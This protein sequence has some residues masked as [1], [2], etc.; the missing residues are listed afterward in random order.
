MWTAQNTVG[1][2][3]QVFDAFERATGAEV[4]TQA[5]PDP[6]ESNV[7]ACTRPTLGRRKIVS[8]ITS[9]AVT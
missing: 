3:D 4:E 1:A 5:V 9:G 6:Y 8:G 7:P 2:P